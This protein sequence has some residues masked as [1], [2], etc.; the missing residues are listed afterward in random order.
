MKAKL[1]TITITRAEGPTDLCD[2]PQTFTSWED[3]N[4]FLIRGSWT[5][6]KGGAYDK[7]DFEV[8]W[9]NGESYHGRFDLHHIAY[10]APNLFLEVSRT[11]GVYAGLI[12]PPHWTEAQQKE[13][14]GWD[15][16]LTETCKRMLE[17]VELEYRQPI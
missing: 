5:A 8:V 15:P 9:E 2:K 6:S 14:L 4:D 16:E 13:I 7:H 3:A 17:S 1:A 10:E 12:R 11:L